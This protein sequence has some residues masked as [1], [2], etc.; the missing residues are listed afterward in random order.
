MSEPFDWAGLGELMGEIT[1]GP[2][3][4]ADLARGILSWLLNLREGRIQTAQSIGVSVIALGY[5]LGLVD[6][7]T[8]DDLAA[9]SGITKQAIDKE[10]SRLR[11]RLSI[12]SRPQ[13][14]TEARTAYATRAITVHAA[15]TARA[16]R[17][18]QPVVDRLRCAAQRAATAG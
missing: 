13:K 18:N 8:L 11:D 2:D 12:A 1:D 5:V 9:P 15:I 14:S 6:G 16:K 3:S 7:D 10:V 17:H 4:R